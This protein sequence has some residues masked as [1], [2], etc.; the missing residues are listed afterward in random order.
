MPLLA[1]NNKLYGRDGKLLGT[2]VTTATYDPVL[3]NNSW[4]DIQKALRNGN[5]AGWTVGD[6]KPLTLTNG[7]TY[8]IR[9]VD[10]QKGRYVSTDGI[11]C[12][13]TFEFV[14]LLKGITRVINSSEKTYEGVT[15]YTA[16]GWLNSDMRSYLKSDVIFLIPEELSSIILLNKVGSASYGGSEYTDTEKGGKLIYSDG[17]KLFLATQCE[18]FGG[19]DVCWDYKTMEIAYPQFDYYKAHH[20]PSDVVKYQLGSTSGDWYWHRSPSYNDPDR[21][22]CVDFIGDIDHGYAEGADG[23]ALCFTL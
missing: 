18:L 8:T 13:A 3:A 10:L 17:D 2:S 15:N 16:G 6:I 12:K 22:C 4:A 23:V 14:E 11:E 7:D 1:K 20:T 9:L 19:N 21:F 5:P